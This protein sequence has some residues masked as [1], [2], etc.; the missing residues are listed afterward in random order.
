MIDLFDKETYRSQVQIVRIGAC[1]LGERYAEF[2]TSF[3]EDPYNIECLVGGLRSENLEVQAETP[4]ALA[5]HGDIPCD[6]RQAPE[7]TGADS[8][9]GHDPAGRDGDAD[10]QVRRLRE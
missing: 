3:V 1:L 10:V 7:G 6:S 2:A 5:A 8:E 9:G 4:R